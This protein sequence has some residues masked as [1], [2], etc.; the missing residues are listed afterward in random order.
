[1]GYANYAF[2]YDPFIDNYKVVSVFCYEFQYFKNLRAKACKTE[3]KVHT[4]GKHSWRRIH[5]FSSTY[6]PRGCES[7]IIVSGSVNWFAYSSV[8]DSCSITIVSLDLG[9]ESYQDI[10]QPDYGDFVRLT[11][12]VMRDFLCLF[13][14][15]DSF[16]DVWLMKIYGNKESWIKLIRLPRLRYHDYRVSSRIVDISEDKNQVLLI[17]IKDYRLLRWF[18]YDARNDIKKIIEI[19]GS[20]WVQSKIYVESLISP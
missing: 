20:D 8:N 3:V 16:T 11:M 2:R 18:V 10:S 17:L 5:N 6:V 15:S 14:Y 19:Q 9:K 12:G 13:S 4:L 1:M 7:G